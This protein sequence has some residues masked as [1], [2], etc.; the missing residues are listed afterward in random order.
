MI[1]VL[2]LAVFLASNP[3]G[4]SL[5]PVAREQE[6]DL[7]MNRFVQKYVL[8]GVPV[9]IKL[10]EG[11]SAIVRAEFEAT[12]LG[13]CAKRKVD[14]LSTGTGRG[15]GAGTGPVPVRNACLTASM[16]IQAFTNTCFLLGCCP[17]AM[18]EG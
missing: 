15:T 10:N 3:A 2:V 12:L 5:Q 11:K 9:I 17:R 8:P 13:P 14:V 18:V 1:T 16:G 4:Q 7:T 6:E